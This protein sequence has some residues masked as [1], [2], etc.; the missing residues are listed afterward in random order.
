M[1]IFQM[2]INNLHLDIIRAQIYT[3]LKSVKYDA[4]MKG[5]SW[6]NIILYALCYTL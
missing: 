4:N 2:T 3:H 6:L 1:F 5:K